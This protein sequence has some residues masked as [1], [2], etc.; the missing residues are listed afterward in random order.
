MTS[1]NSNERRKCCICGKPFDGFGNNPA[2]VK[3]SGRCCDKCNNQTVLP[4]RMGQ[5]KA[6]WF[7]GQES[8]PTAIIIN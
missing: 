6:K 3:N 1:Y 5:I 7:L 8:S 2:P 4:A